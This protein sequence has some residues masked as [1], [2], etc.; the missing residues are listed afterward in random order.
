MLSATTAIT[1]RQNTKFPEEI[2]VTVHKKAGT[3][4]IPKNVRAQGNKSLVSLAV[5]LVISTIIVNMF[6]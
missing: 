1:V 3:Y 6:F 2:T 4:Y 5:S